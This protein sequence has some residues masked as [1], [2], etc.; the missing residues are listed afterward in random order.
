M[1]K[2]RNLTQICTRNDPINRRIQ[3]FSFCDFDNEVRRSR[4]DFF[5]FSLPNLDFKP[6]LDTEMS[7]EEEEIKRFKDWVV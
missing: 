5:Q 6:S 2:T 4:D 7:L 3:G 1:R